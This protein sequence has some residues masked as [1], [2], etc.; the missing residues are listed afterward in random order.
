MRKI[1]EFEVY[2]YFVLAVNKRKRVQGPTAMPKIWTQ[3]PDELI[4]VSFNDFGQPNDEKKACTLAHFLGTI[5][6]NGRY[7]PLNYKDWRLMP[8][9]YKDEMLKIVKVL[10]YYIFLFHGNIYSSFLL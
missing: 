8:R 10:I 5:A 3:S 4:V 2:S 1:K 6:R 9:S 7:C